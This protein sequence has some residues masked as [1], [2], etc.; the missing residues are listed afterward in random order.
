MNG[1][2]SIGK[3]N[4]TKEAVDDFRHTLCLAGK[5]NQGHS[6]YSYLKLVYDS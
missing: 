1:I 2:V 4:E 3:Y 5:E 6:E